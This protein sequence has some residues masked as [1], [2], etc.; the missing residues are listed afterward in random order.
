MRASAPLPPEG[1]SAIVHRDTAHAPQ[2]AAAQGIRSRDL[3]RDGVVDGVIPEFPDAAEEPT[4]FA[5]RVG[6]AVARELGVLVGQ[7][8]TLRYRRRLERYRKLG[9][10]R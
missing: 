7:D 5:K 4:E 3:L 2:M 10:P 6:A 1:A 8:A 9:L